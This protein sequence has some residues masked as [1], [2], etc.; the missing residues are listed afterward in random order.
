MSNYLQRKGGQKRKNMLRQKE[1]ALRGDIGRGSP[2]EKLLKSAENLR[3]AYLGYIKV[4]LD[5]TLPRRREDEAKAAEPLERLKAANTHWTTVSA[6]AIIEAHSTET[7]K[8]L[9]V[10]RKSWWD[11]RRR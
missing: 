6:Q 4:L 9:F 11:F 7:S 10:D 3:A 2:Q 8:I 1:L 5:E